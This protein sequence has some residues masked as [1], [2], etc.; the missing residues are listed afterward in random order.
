MTSKP[1]SVCAEEDKLGLFHKPGKS[2]YIYFMKIT[3][4]GMN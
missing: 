1:D 2:F 4:F 3:N